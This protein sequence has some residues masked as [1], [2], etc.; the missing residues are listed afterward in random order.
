MSD[1]FICVKK[2]STTATGEGVANPHATL[3]AAL[4]A[5]KMIAVGVLKA[6][7]MRERNVSSKVNAFAL[8]HSAYIYADGNDAATSSITSRPRM[9]AN[10]NLAGTWSTDHI[11]QVL[12]GTAAWDNL[13]RIGRPNSSV[14]GVGEI[15]PGMTMTANPL[16]HLV[17]SGA[18]SI[19][20][21][22]KFAGDFNDFT[23]VQ[24]L[25]PSGD[26]YTSDF[27]DKDNKRENLYQNI[28][29]GVFTG[30]YHV[31]SGV[32]DRITD[33]R[34]TYI[35]PSSIHTDGTFNYECHIDSPAIVAKESRIF[36]RLAAPRSNWDGNGA[37]FDGE[38]S[39]EY[40]IQ[41]IN[42]K[43]PNG[44]TVIKYE[45]IV[46]RGDAD[47][48]NSN[49]VNFGT[50]A[51]KPEINKFLLY[52]WQEGYPLTGPST[53][54]TLSFDVV[55]R[56]LDDPFDLGFDL[57]YEENTDV[58]DSTAGS[59][60]YLAIDGSPLSTQNQSMGINPT[61]AV[62]ISAIEI[63]NSGGLVGL[64]R[65]QYFPIHMK[66]RPSGDSLERRAMPASILSWDHNS[67][68]YPLA[69]SVWN[70]PNQAADNTTA[71]GSQNLI[72]HLNYLNDSYYINLDRMDSQIADSGRLAVQFTLNNL[73][74][75]VKRGQFGFGHS[76]GAFDVG[77]KK[78]LDVF[79]K[80]TRASLRIRARKASG[81]LNR[82]CWLD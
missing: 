44:I 50:Y 73:D 30:K 71:S 34:D 16:M 9:P 74:A 8:V 39:H 70:S 81:L 62:R 55:G 67:G 63:C 65:E 36:F 15:N 37:N 24:K 80:P 5:K 60:D 22:D 56:S 72:Q 53:G 25:Y 11:R 26:V 19:P 46:M 38:V 17:G 54:Y 64:G 40:T 42:W 69:S 49:Y 76:K 35:Q 66:V 31:P 61:N 79:F 6:T 18:L 51:S 58:V 23:C 77:D 82:R 78:E 3:V 57:G 21:T 29:E 41:N 48:D 68:V 7:M 33:D 13:Y 75:P 52:Q 45:D 43:D 47:Y 27:V 10:I 2:I 1:C 32:S 4:H 59:N 20:Y 14:S 12:E 28:D